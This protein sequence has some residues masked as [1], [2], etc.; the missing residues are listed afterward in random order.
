VAAAVW[1]I[2]PPWLNG[3]TVKRYA[4]VD[5]RIAELRAQPDGATVTAGLPLA[6][7]AG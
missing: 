1:A 3:N 6:P 5:P 4:L 7:G 2:N